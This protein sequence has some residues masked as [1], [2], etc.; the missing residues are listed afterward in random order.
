MKQFVYKSILKDDMQELY[1]CQIILVMGSPHI[2]EMKLHF[3]KLF[4]RRYCKSVTSL[5]ITFTKLIGSTTVSIVTGETKEFSSSLAIRRIN[6]VS[7]GG[8]Q[9]M[10]FNCGIVTILY[11]LLIG[12]GKFLIFPV[13]S[14]S[15]HFPKFP[16]FPN[17]VN[18]HIAVS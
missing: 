13:V 14:S 11:V 1:P 9:A 8:I 4:S 5:L 12:F 10:S 6:Y 3:G 16:K 17:F 2:H 7:R 18:N 15:A